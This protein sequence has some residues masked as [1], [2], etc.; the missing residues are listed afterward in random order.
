MIRLI[1]KFK[2]KPNLKL[3]PYNQYYSKYDN[4][5]LKILRTHNIS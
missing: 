4:K 1:R 5:Y 2:C 3:K